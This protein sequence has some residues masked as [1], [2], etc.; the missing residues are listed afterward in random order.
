MSGFS[1]L[2]FWRFGEHYGRPRVP[3]TAA[4]HAHEETHVRVVR[5]ALDA[6][7]SSGDAP[8]GLGPI[9]LRIPCFSDSR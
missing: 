2:F 3:R 7:F 6:G 5:D 8:A 9:P 1:L 4:P